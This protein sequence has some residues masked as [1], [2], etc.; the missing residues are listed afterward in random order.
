MFSNQLQKGLL[1]G[2]AE[3]IVVSFIGLPLLKLSSYSCFLAKLTTE[4]DKVLFDKTLGYLQP[5]NGHWSAINTELIGL[6]V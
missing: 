2:K 6:K 5:L 1:T 4:L 3:S